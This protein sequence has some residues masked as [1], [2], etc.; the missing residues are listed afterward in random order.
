MTH[1][2][3]KSGKPF[4]VGQVIDQTDGCSYDINVIFQFPDY[5]NDYDELEVKFVNFYF[6]AYNKE[7][8]D[9]YIAD[10]LSKAN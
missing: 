8:T 9:D 10:F 6:G 2:H 3:K 1:I 5:D 7:I 4:E